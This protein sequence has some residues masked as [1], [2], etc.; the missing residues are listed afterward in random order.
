L[1]YYNPPKKSKFIIS[2]I[3]STPGLSVIDEQIAVIHI[4]SNKPWF[5]LVIFIGDVV[6]V[7]LDTTVSLNAFSVH[8]LFNVPE[9]LI[10]KN[11]SAV[12]LLVILNILQ[13]LF[14]L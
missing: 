10:D 5:I 7:I 8:P 14:D 12:P 2:K 6:N 13:Y 3:I 11:P 9:Y 4:Y 1:P